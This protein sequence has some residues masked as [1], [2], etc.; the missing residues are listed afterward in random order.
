LLYEKLIK[1]DGYSKLISAIDE[2]DYTI[3]DITTPSHKVLRGGNTHIKL[4]EEV[5]LDL[6]EYDDATLLYQDVNSISSD[7]YTITLDNGDDSTTTHY[8]WVSTPN[9]FLY[10]NMIVLYVGVDSELI[11]FI[12]KE[13]QEQITGMKYGN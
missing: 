6:Y 8:E 2:S 12:S 11:Q 5:F 7:G 9:F 10:D 3:V 4:G 13:S 1:I